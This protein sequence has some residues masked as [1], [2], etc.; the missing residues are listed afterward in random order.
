MATQTYSGITNQQKTFYDR[1]LLE[2][3]LPNVV[4]LKYGQKRSIPK[5]EG[6]TINFRRFNSLTANTTPLEEGVTPSGNSLNVSAIPAVVKGYGDFIVISDLLDMA[7]IDPVLTETV[8]LLGEQAAVKLD[9]VV[10]DQLKAGTNV[11]RVNNRAARNLVVSTDVMDGTTIRNARRKMKRNNVK[12]YSGAGAYIAFVHPDVA[13]DIMGD[14]AWINA[15]Q[16]A[17][18]TKIFDGEL[19]KLYGIRFIETTL[20]PIFTGLGSG[21]IDVYGSIIIGND[22]YGIPDIAGSSKPETIIKQLGS[23]GTADPLN[24]RA[25]AGW[26]A[27]LAAV[28][29]DEACILRVESAVSVA[30]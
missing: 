25:S 19:G 6:A 30:S 10:V 23:A 18:S 16:Y 17:G 21:D 3:L 26:K 14:S 11:L 8:E 15:N 9:M 12:P 1:V 29:L 5:H 2:R 7:G 27:Y 13:H 22:A 4:F 24:Q 28:R 20:T